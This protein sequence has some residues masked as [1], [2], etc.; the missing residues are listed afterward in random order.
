VGIHLECLFETIYRKNGKQEQSTAVIIS[1]SLCRTNAKSR[2]FNVGSTVCCVQA[3]FH[4]QNVNQGFFPRNRCSMPWQ[5]LS[6]GLN[7][8]V[9]IRL[10]AYRP[11]A[12]ALETIN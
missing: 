2:A 5:Y 8:S 3:L 11:C 10:F 12:T 1:R 4:H 7:I 6:A 9:E